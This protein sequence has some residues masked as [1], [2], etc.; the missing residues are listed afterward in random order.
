M[1]P[2]NQDVEIYAGTNITTAGD[3]RRLVA[4]CGGY[5]SN[6]RG[7]NAYEENVANAKLIA[8]LWNTARGFN[9][10]D[11]LAAANALPDVIAALEAILA[12]DEVGMPARLG[13]QAERSLA[14]LKGGVQ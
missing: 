10:A 3:G 4:N 14:A 6:R 12:S 9:P 8:A 11:P 2:T 13:R 1:K 7:E 5:Q